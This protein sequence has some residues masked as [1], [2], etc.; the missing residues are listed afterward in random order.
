[1]S[2]RFEE[3][4]GVYTH[5]AEVEPAKSSTN[6][7]SKVNQYSLNSLETVESNKMLFT[8]RERIYAEHAGQLMKSMAYPSKDDTIGMITAGLIKNCPVSVDGLFLYQ[9]RFRGRH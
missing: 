9:R 7:K 4:D 5:T 6:D 3:K 8:P 2:L 1:M